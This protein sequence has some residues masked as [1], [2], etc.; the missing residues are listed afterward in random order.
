MPLILMALSATSILNPVR[1]AAA[2]VEMSEM[3]ALYG[4]TLALL[5]V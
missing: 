5:R 3:N 2:F 4:K 1:T